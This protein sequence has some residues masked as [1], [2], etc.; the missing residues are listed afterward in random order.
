MKTI[1][2][3]IR[4]LFA[5]ANKIQMLWGIGIL[6][7]ML[8]LAVLHH[9]W[10]DDPKKLGRWR[11]LCLLPLLIC[12]AHFVIYVSSCTA[13]LSY[14]IP[15]YLLGI[16]ALFPIITAK[17]KIG[18]R[19]M[20]IPVVLLSAA[21]GFYYCGTAP[22][23]FNF[24]RQSYTDSFRA[25]I[26]T[27]D[28]FYVLKE[29]KEVDFAALEANYLPLVQT[30][31]REQNPAKLEEAVELIK[32]ELH[33]GHVYVDG[34]FDREAY[35]TDRK[36]YGY[37]LG[38]VRLN[39]GEVI[40]VCT[41][42]SVQEHGITDG[43]V[44]TKWNGKPVLQAAD[45]DVPDLG[46]PV[47]A[48]D[49][50]ISVMNVCITGG[51]TVE[52]AFLDKNGTEQTVTLSDVGNLE[53]HHKAF[54]LLN[55]EQDF[56]TNAEIYAANFSTKMLNDKCGY[57]QLLAEGTEYD[58]QDIL[59]YLMGD[60]KWARDMFR[61]KLN[62][63]KTQGMEYLVIDLRNNMGGIDE[64]GCA[65]CDLLT[66][67]DWYGQGT[68]IR[69]N[70]QYTCVSDHGIHGTGEFAD[71]QVVAL[72]NYNCISAGDGTALYLSKLP[73]VTL[74]GITDPCGCNQETGGLCV[75]ADGAVA[76]GFP[77]GLVLDETGVP[78]VETKA[79]RI[80]RNPVEERIPLDHDAAMA[81]FRDGQDYELDWAI[82]YLE[83]HAA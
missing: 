21:A 38:M 75:L 79:D 63:L 27:M 18:H 80:S 46:M 81:I 26:Q 73:N 82:K 2:G 20:M 53:A 43:T 37:G 24:T 62:D 42:E 68:G 66:D 12:I 3:T 50:F 41:E 15:L 39:N 71:L 35:R 77:T 1:L 9:I 70:G 19:I 14:Y 28:R 36:F 33:D 5:T 7:V 76:I 67:Q 69:K 47:Q 8:I 52:V 44:I 4:H 78:N 34:D 16:L 56:E 72:T 22:N 55:K 61:D 59:G 23:V 60:H 49:D 6:A 74:A 31:E 11:L 10:R 32:N 30:A 83:D 58:V 45:E 57:I 48:N 64:I 13:L 17:R 54:E 25:M 65:L 51:D 40:A 29:W